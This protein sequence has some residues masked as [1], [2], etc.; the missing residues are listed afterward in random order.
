[1]NNSAICK[2]RKGM[3][4]N[5]TRFANRVNSPDSENRDILVSIFS[6]LKIYKLSCSELAKYTYANKS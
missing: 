2:N 1:M 6:E 4:R 3:A 5:I